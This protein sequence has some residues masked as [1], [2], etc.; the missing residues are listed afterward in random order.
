MTG[1]VIVL[2]WDALDIEVLDE[3]G[4]GDAF[5]G[6]HRRIETHVNP[7]I[8]EPHTRELWPTLITGRLPDG[9]G[10]HAATEG[11]GVA[12]DSPL[13]NRASAAAQGVVPQAVRTAIGRRL[14]E[15]GA[16][17]EA[18]GQEHYRAHG[19]ETVFDAYDSRPI[20]IPN[21]ETERDRRLGL[22]ANRDRRC[23]TGC[24]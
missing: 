18:Y 15:R 23:A 5:G 12:W 19:I 20:S 6:Q 21:H 22:D 11:D 14:R 24:F 4:L 16:A 2:G 17:V 7:V 9:H 13:L 3:L 1:P 8:G 10:I